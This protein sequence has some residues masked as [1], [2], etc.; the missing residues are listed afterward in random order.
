MS[1]SQRAQSAATRTAS[2]AA[3][4]AR[5]ARREWELRRIHKHIEENEALIGRLL[6]PMLAEGHMQIESPE[7]SEAVARIRLLG[8]EL[9]AKRAE[10]A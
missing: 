2:I 3:Q 8:A 10:A 9:D 7:V 4:T 1:I 5:R 6:Y